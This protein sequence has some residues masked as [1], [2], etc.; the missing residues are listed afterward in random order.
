MIKNRIINFC[1]LIIRRNFLFV[2][3]LYVFCLIFKYKPK[4]N[5]R[6]VKISFINTHDQSGGAAKIA[7]LIS[8]NV[9]RWFPIR[10]YVLEQKREEDDWIRK[11]EEKRY[12]FWQE[13]LRREAKQ[14]GWLEFAGFHS[15]QL[16]NDAFYESS[17]LVHLHNLHGEFFSPALFSIV[18]RRKK[19]IWTLHDESILTGHCSCTLGCER[20]KTGCGN[21]PDLSIYPSINYDNTK[22]VLLT[23]KKWISKL[24]PTVVCP[25]HWLA[26][27]LRFAYPQLKEIKVI[28][29]GVNTSVFLPY[30]KQIVRTK[31]NLPLQSKLILFVAEYATN[32]PFKGG[33]IIRQL[34]TDL[35]LKDYTF[36][37]VGGENVSTFDNHIT[38]PYV[39]DE[40][41]LSELYSAC[42]ILLY[43]TQ[44]DNLPLVVLE[45]MSSGTPVIA[46]NLG[47]IP[48]IISSEEYGFLIDNYSCAENFKSKLVSFF[49]YSLEQQVDLRK[50]VRKRIVEEY[51]LD[52]MIDSYKELY[53]TVNSEK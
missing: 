47:G 37:T 18:F 42:D 32:N 20:W 7:Y 17:T 46:S 23:K 14:K 49:D 36:I 4:T 31:L 21:C 43:P 12:P 5:S 28:P 24:Q 3:R 52:R 2:L 22:N 8:N 30:D 27:R 39:K 26:T 9:Q 51:S 25:S 29:N 48:E 38:F 44:A 45:S 34:I 35:D 10:F 40:I 41:I 6:D 19:V 50:M 11:I 33:D 1:E 53:L 16:L 15:L 13:L